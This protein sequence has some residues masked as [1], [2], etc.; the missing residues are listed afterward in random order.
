MIRATV[1]T[2]WNAN[3]E[4]EIAESV[5]ANL[6]EQGRRRVSSVTCPVHLSL[7]SVTWAKT[8]DGVDASVEDPCCDTLQGAL[9]AA[10]QRAL[11]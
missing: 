7:H 10:A 6:L 9:E 2:N 4:K 8:R 3:L 5:M 11:R 1:K